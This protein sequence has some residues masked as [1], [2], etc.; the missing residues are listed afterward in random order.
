[1]LLHGDRR[2]EVALGALVDHIRRLQGLSFVHALF[3]LFVGEQ[4]VSRVLHAP[5]Q[6]TVVAH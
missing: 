5:R 1:M 6:L 4:D 2:F 3:Q